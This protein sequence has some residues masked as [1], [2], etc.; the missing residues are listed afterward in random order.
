MWRRVWW[1]LLLGGLGLIGIGYGVPELRTNIPVQ[2]AITIVVLACSMAA[3]GIDI[4]VIRK[5]RKQ[6]MAET[7]KG[8]KK[9]PT[10]GKDAES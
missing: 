9:P 5:L 10:S 3:L 6:I 1:V 8:K 7:G 2:R 4:F